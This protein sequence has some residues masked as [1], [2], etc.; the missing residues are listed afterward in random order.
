M[1]SGG[2]YSGT[3]IPKTAWLA[4]A[5][6]GFTVAIGLLFAVEAGRNCNKRQREFDLAGE[7]CLPFASAD[8]F[9]GEWKLV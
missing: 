3:G 6:A 9:S 2:N 1:S 7:Y 4:R 8:K 5:A